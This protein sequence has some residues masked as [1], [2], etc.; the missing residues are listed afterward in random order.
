MDA[1][2]SGV[3]LKNW[4]SQAHGRRPSGVS[5]NSK[6]YLAWL[7]GYVRR[8]REAAEAAESLAVGLMMDVD[9]SDMRSFGIADSM[10]AGSPEP[11]IAE[12][13]GF[14]VAPPQAKQ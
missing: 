3:A 5:A 13:V 9:G 8:V 7:Q 1:T 12:V 6:P 10:F 14:S 2:T 11:L 4:S